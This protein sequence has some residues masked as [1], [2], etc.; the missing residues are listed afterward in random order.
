MGQKIPDLTSS[1]VMSGI[2]FISG[3]YAIRRNIK[4]GNG[5]D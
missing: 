2:T 5:V 3:G 4:G 1:V